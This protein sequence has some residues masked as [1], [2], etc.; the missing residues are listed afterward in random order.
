MEQFFKKIGW[1]SIITSL[2]FA[3]LGLFIA[4]YPNTTFQIIS[5]VLGAIL[6]AYG[7]IKI[8]EYFQMKDMNILYGTEL[9]FGVIAAL[10][11]LVVIIC[12]DMIQA[13]IRILIGIWIVYSAIMRFSGAIKFRNFN[14]NNKIWIV[15][16]IMALTMLFC[17]IY[18]IT[19]P[20]VIMM[21]IGIIMVIY[22]IMDIIEECIFMKNIKD[23]I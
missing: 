1:T 6:I 23:I 5:N 11:G 20:G 2:G 16:I 14:S 8:I 9:S 10:L 4:C 22:S 13:M 15:G 12:S 21:Y 3:I 7:T 19:S 18:I 17:G